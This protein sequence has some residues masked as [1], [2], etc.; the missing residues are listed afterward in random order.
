M[1]ATLKTLLANGES[2]IGWTHFTFNPW[3]GCDKIAPECAHCYI[4]REIRKHVDWQSQLSPT[5]KRKPWGEVYLTKTWKDPYH[6]QL[7][8]RD[9]GQAVRVFTCSLSD[10]FHARVDDRK[11]GWNAT[12]THKRIGQTLSNGGS[13]QPFR[14]WY[15]ATYHGADVHWRDAAWQVVRDTPQCVYLILT[16]RPELISSRLPADWGDGYPNVWLGTS[17]GCRQTLNKIDA[18]RQIPVHPQAVRFVSSEPLL[19]D[20]SREINLD[21]IG[22]LIAGGESGTNPEYLWNPLG[23]WKAELKSNDGRRTMRIEWAYALMLRAKQAGIPF[24]FKQITATKS[25][26]G[27]DALGFEM[28]EIPN[29]HSGLIWAAKE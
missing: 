20:I 2:N 16:K 27:E 25:G 24:F 19:E 8:L 1:A 28:R 23:D 15:T 11:L 12:I 26:V 10:F 4:Y 7:A 14:N 21:G 22:W 29:A 9:T 17:V 3:V 13:G 18:L 6:W 5:P